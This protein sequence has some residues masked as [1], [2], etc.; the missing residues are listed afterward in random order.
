CHS[1][2]H[3]AHWHAQQS[4]SKKIAPIFVVDFAHEQEAEQEHYGVNG[5]DDGRDALN[6]EIDGAVVCTDD[7]PLMAKTLLCHYHTPNS[8]R[9]RMTVS[10]RLIMSTVAADF[11]ALCLS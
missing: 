4:E 6:D 3:L 8:L 7:E 1:G 9:P 10:A 2:Q 11:C 5:H